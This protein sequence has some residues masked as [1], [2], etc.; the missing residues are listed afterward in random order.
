M[1]IFG[2]WEFL[3]LVVH[4]QK[5]ILIVVQN[6][7]LKVAQLQMK[8]DIWKFGTWYSCNQNAVLEM[9]NQI[10]QYWVIYPR[11]ALIPV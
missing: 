10:F 1:I 7:V 2:Q 11:K 9:E 6:M 8:T 3:V 4:V 5:F